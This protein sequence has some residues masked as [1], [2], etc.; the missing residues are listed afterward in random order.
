M[1]CELR[2]HL[3]NPHRDQLISARRVTSLLYLPNVPAGNTHG[4]H[5]HKLIKGDFGDAGG[6]KF[7]HKVGTHSVKRHRNEFLLPNVGKTKR[8]HLGKE[9]IVGIELICSFAEACLEVAF[10]DEPSGF[11]LQFKMRRC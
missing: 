5:S 9:S 3:M 7:N 8:S 4:P 1:S 2:R 10:T 6:T 11:R